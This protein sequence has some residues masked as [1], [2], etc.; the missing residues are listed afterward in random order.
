MVQTRE[1]RSLNCGKN[2]TAL[3]QARERMMK[4]QSLEKNPLKLRL[5]SSLLMIQLSG[6]K[7]FLKVVY[8]LPV[9]VIVVI[10]LILIVKIIISIAKQ[11]CFQYA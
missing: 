6:E 8:L 4:C 1:C 10:V 9:V 7:I 2:V 11:R 3:I 5:N